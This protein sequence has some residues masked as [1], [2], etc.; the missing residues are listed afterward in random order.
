MVEADI[1]TVDDTAAVEFVDVSLGVKRAV[2][3]AGES[4]RVSIPTRRTHGNTVAGGPIGILVE[5]S[6]SGLASSGVVV[7]DGMFVIRALDNALPGV[8]VGKAVVAVI[9]LDAGVDAHVDGVVGESIVGEGAI[10]V[11]CL[12]GDVAVESVGTFGD[13]RVVGGVGK[14]VGRAELYAGA[15]ESL[16]CRHVGV[17]VH[18]GS[19]LSYTLL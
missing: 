19:T 9:V 4:D 13:T 10:G 8:Q 14:E 15:I 2:L 1:F 12:V 6:A 18:G 7:F 11:A 17:L 16:S 3:D 5:P